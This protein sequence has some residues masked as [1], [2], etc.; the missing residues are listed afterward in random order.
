MTAG[1]NIDR[2]RFLTT[3]AAAGAGLLLGCRLGQRGLP[4]GSG[5]LNAWIHVGTDDWV[6]MVISESEMGQGI[7]TALSQILA[8]E[9][10]AD[11]HRVRAVHAPADRDKYGWQYTSGSTSVR[12]DYNSLRRA[13]AAARQMLVSAAAEGWDVS[14]R[15][16]RAESGSVVH[17]PT[18]RRVK[19]GE[20]AEAASKLRLPRRPRLKRPEDFRYIGQSLRR[21][22]GWEKVTGAAVYGF[23]VSVPGMLVAV[24]ARCPVFGG[25]VAEWDPQ[26]ALAIPGV[27]HAVEISTGI[28]I[29][30]DDLSAATRGRSTLHVSW[31]DREW[32]GL[33]SQRIS[34]IL[35]E[36]CGNGER[37]FEF[38]RP[39]RL[40]ERA[41]RRVEAVYEV[42]YLA[43]ATME[44][45]SCAAHVRPDGC[46]LW[47]GTQAQSA[48]QETAARLTGLPIER[49][50]VHTMYLGGGFGRRAHQQF[51]AE[52]V[53]IAR[54]VGQPV[55]L[56]YT[57]ED[58]MR[59]GWYR[60]T[61]YNEL[62]GGLDATGRPVAW[63]HRIAGRQTSVQGAADI[64]YRISGRKVTYAQPRLPIPTTIWRSVGYSQN[65]YVTECFFDELAHAGGADPVELRLDLLG[66]RPKH[67]RVLRAV[68]EAAGWGGPL[69]QG[70]GRGVAL[71]GCFGS[72]VAQVAEVS[73]RPDGAPRVHRVVCAV[74]CGHTINPDLVKAQMEGGIGFG[75]SA[76][77]YGEITIAEGRAVQS[78]FHDYPILRMSE[79]PEVDV[80]IV[81][82]GAVLGGI[83]EVGVPPIA[84]AVCNALFALTGKPVRKLPIGVVP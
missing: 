12:Q 23:D 58:D 41:D 16:C 66:G 53:Q 14:R 45:M 46:E 39:D 13:G 83:G 62:T 2:R 18:G 9:M 31:D 3:G 33:S 25:Q 44:P 48:C 26:P 72:L 36:A 7:L 76:A 63:I 57:R 15:E 78:N 73:L 82:S 84:P 71:A 19:Y 75:L 37:A 56:L 42:P 74:D 80:H 28:A 54:E 70:H 5:D 32:G 17:V 24:V 50:R 43:H 51:V 55:Q 64:P 52:A 22:D 65:T 69:P 47:V 27:R 81:E 67:R 11:W 59:A 4:R 35:R 49:V 79:M 30:G 8:D 1:R 21:L 68:A 38:G 10:E 40:L 77:L 34:E 6:T 20:L 60:P 61:S 29:V